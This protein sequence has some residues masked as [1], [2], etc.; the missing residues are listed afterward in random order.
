M[1]EVDEF[2]G[3]KPLHV[4]SLTLG[5]WDALLGSSAL[6]TAPGT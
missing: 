3:L 2:G 5:L 6:R 1:V 4:L